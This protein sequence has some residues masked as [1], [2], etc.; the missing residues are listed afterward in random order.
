MTVV[1]EPVELP[2]ETAPADLPITARGF[3]SV[4][5]AERVA[6]T[7]GYTVRLISRLI[8]LERLAG[9]TIAT[10]YTDGL[11]SVDRGYPNAKT[12][13]ATS[14]SEI[15]GAAMSVNVLRDGV[16]K[17]HLVFAADMMLPLLDSNSPYTALALSLV[18]HEC[19]HVADLKHRDEKF[20]GTIL[21]N[22]YNGYY[23]QMI[24]PLADI[25][26]EEYAA[27]RISAVFSDKETPRFEESLVSVSGVAQERSKAAIRAYRLHGNL[28]RVLAKAGNALCEPL[29]MMAYL[30]GQL[31]GL[32][33]DL[34]QAPAARTLLACSAYGAISD[35]LTL[36]LRDLWERRAGW[37]SPAEFEPLRKLCVDTFALGGIFLTPAPDGNVYVHIPFTPGT[38]PGEGAARE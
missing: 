29:R 35:Q 31:D 26:W 32:G 3:S 22:K 2:P 8:D 9:I 33:Q 18:A 28:N 23:Q 1:D 30:R 15:V 13:T 25:L 36:A 21:Q 10:D 17:A 6:Y 24:Y 19:G 12:P 4:E 14:S 38:M 11:A 20:P 5:E 37:A 7:V 27:C 16:V 34:D